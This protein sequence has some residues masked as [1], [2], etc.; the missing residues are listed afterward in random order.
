MCSLVYSI[1]LSPFDLGVTQRV[2]LLAQYEE[3]V[4][5]YRL[6]MSVEHLSGLDANW[7]SLNRSFLERMRG[8]LMVWRNMDP[9]LFCA[10]IIQDPQAHGEGVRA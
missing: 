5:S 8:F 9:A 1:G 7:T 2:T 6:H 4:K 3:A 10:A